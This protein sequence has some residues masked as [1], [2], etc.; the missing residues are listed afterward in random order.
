VMKVKVR[1]NHSHLSTI[2]IPKNG[3]LSLDPVLLEF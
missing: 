3:N 1:C 2:I